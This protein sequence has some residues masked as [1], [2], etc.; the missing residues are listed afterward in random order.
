MNSRRGGRSRLPPSASHLPRR[1]LVGAAALIA[2]AMLAGATWIAWPPPAS[3][4]ATSV[5][6]GVTLQDRY[7]V[8]LRTS[9]AGDGTRVRWMPIGEIDPDI[10]RA[11]VA[12]EDRRF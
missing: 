4:T 11:F 10:I 7:G 6:S 12:V 1:L 5:A 9:R 2:A 3:L 8:P